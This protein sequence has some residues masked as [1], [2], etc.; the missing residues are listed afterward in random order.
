MDE[1]RAEQPTD[2]SVVS[3][4]LGMVNHLE[5]ETQLPKELRR[6]CGLGEQRNEPTT[7]FGTLQS[8]GADDSAG[9]PLH[10]VLQKKRHATIKKSF[11]HRIGM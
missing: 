3:R 8:Q 9:A 6:T 1:V 2:V 11:H 7:R 10:C 4:L 5:E